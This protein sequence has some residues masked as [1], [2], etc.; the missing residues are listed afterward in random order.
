MLETLNPIDLRPNSVEPAHQRIEPQGRLRCF[1]GEM[2]VQPTMP[3]HW[4]TKRLQAILGCDT[5]EAYLVRLWC[6]CHATKTSTM[7]IDTDALAGTCGWMGDPEVF[8]K[9]LIDCRWAE[10]D[11]E[12]LTAIGWDDHNASLI[13]AWFNGKKGGRPRKNKTQRLTQDDT[14]LTQN[15]DGIPDRLDRL[16]GFDLKDEK[17]SAAPPAPSSKKITPVSW[18]P[19]TGFTVNDDRMS[20]WKKTYPGVD[21]ASELRKANLWLIENPRKRKKD[22]ARFMASWLGRVTPKTGGSAHGGLPRM[23]SDSEAI[24]K[25]RREREARNKN[26]QPS[27]ADIIAEDERREAAGLG[28]RDAR[29]S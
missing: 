2:I 19:T 25:S 13:A 15:G 10:R 7:R 20:L 22:Y 8:E 29:A 6:H 11:G 23:L 17:E 14:G 28:V 16:D 5:A 1:G 3:Y 21:I 26:K 24:E 9:A 4:K 12:Y 18:T 27:L